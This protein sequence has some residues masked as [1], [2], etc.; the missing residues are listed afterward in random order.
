MNFIWALSTKGQSNLKLWYNQPATKWT[1]A[2]PV[3]SGT[4]ERMVFGGVGKE[5]IQPNEAS[6]WTVGPHKPTKDTS[7]YIKSTR[8]I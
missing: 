1:Q 2:L 6:L 4:L 8:L 3:G 5:L 7:A